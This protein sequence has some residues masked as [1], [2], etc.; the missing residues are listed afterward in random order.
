MGRPLVNALRELWIGQQGRGK[1]DAKAG[2]GVTDV[3]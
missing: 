3:R 2:H 1:A